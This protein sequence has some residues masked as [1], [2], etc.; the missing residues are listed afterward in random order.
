MLIK[1]M[2]TNFRTESTDACDV[3]CCD[4]RT[5]VLLV[6]CST[7]VWS[8]QSF[9]WLTL[10]T[11]LHSDRPV[12]ARARANNDKIQSF[13][14]LYVCA[15][16]CVVSFKGSLS[17]AVSAALKLLSCTSK[18]AE[19]WLV[20][21]ESEPTCDVHQVLLSFSTSLDAN[22]SGIFGGRPWEKVAGK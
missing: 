7:N 19:P 9:N 2:A 3:M 22:A 16:T 10:P 17:P 21:H 14:T 6:T 8:V 5:I 15:S 11:T 13:C 18:F 12:E 4:Y 20:S 1:A